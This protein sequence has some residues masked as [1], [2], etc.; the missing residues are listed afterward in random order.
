MDAF[1]LSHRWLMDTGAARHFCSRK[2][3]RS[4]GWKTYRTSKMVFQ[5][6]AG[7]TTVDQAVD[8]PLPGVS[9]GCVEVLILEDAPSLLSVGKLVQQDGA[10]FTWISGFRPCLRLKD[11]LVIILKS[12][13][14]VPYMDAECLEQSFKLSE[15]EIARLTG[16]D[17]SS[18]ADGHGLVKAAVT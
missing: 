9:K 17:W 8:I 11:G 5:T 3:V 6:A 18:F 16:V 4:A 2:D 12:E 15:G 1:M 13:R 10:S 7:E 14:N